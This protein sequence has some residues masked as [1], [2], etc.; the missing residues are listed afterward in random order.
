[1]KD[2]IKRRAF[3]KYFG[4]SLSF[5]FFPSYL[6]SCYSKNR[7]I[8]MGICSDV[9]HD[10]MPD[11]EAR[12]KTFLDEATKTKAD[13]IIQLGDFCL[14]R[15][16]N[17][18]FLDL[19]NTFKGQKYHVLGNH[20]MDKSSK[21]QMMDFLGVDQPYYSFDFKEVHFVVLD[22]NF[23]KDG[24]E[25]IEFDNGNYLK[26]SGQSRYFITKNQVS[27]L[28]EDLQST[29]KPTII[30]SHQSFQN[31]Y[32]CKNGELVRE[33]LEKE[34]ERVG[35]NKVMACFNGHDHTDGCE[36]VKGITYVHINSMSEYW[37]G[38]KYKCETRYSA[39]INKKYSA[40]KY[41]APYKDPLYAFVEIELGNSIKVEGKTSEWIAP[42]PQELGYDDTKKGRVKAVPVM[43]S[44]NISLMN[45]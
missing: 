23:Y 21:Q 35:Y 43:S 8:R 1:M 11:S 13:F 5:A 26:H 3:L 16:K 25:L 19:W 41:V 36:Y 24:E 27:W 38:R 12:L 6:T 44:R 10:L 30:F 4:A 28:Q 32:S 39:V 18:P 29:D 45:Q 7:K 22:P 17:Q 9:H 42:S 37:L 31:P 33:V 14:P 15:E 2:T 20:D 40:L 34:N